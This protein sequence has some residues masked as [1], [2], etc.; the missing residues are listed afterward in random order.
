M[1]DAKLGLGLATLFV[2]GSMMGSGVY[3]LPASLGTVGSSSLLAWFAAIA[4]ALLFASVFG[5]LASDGGGADFIS[6]I[7]E[8]FGSRTA[9]VAAAFYWLQ[10]VL[11]NIALAVATTGYLSAIFP[12]ITG[13]VTTVVT[14]GILWC[15]TLLALFGPRLVARLEGWTL[16]LG[17]IPVLIAATVGWFWFD[18]AVFRASWNVSGMSLPAALPP[19]VVTILWAFLG[20]ESAGLAAGMVR[21]PAVTVPR[22]TILGVL[23]AAVVYLSACTMITGILP[24]D[25]LARSDAPF[26]DAANRLFGAGL[27]I[28]VALC[29]ALRACGTLG[30]WVL[31]TA[32]SG[33]LAVTV[34]R[35]ATGHEAG[36]SP[37]NI[38]AN[39]ALLTVIALLIADASLAR[40]FTVVIN[41][42]VIV[43]LCVYAIAAAALFR[44]RRTGD[45]RGV[46]IAT[47]LGA[48]GSLVAIAIIAT[49]P[50]EVLAATAGTLLAAMVAWPLL[51]RRR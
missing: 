29:A 7:G 25:V 38:L 39:G 35:S 3:L 33:R 46:D 51:A 49:Q 19:T 22:A 32:E 18:P 48:A 5:R 1:K 13:K 10:G 47:A 45:A 23:G 28:F 24:A 15:F 21:D 8:A 17:L 34:R 41:A 42:A 44:L 12:A 2:A 16:A 36:P 9:F 43:M 14:L 4:V 50:A 11:G 37:L 6:R 26:A 20:L 40:Q 30:G 31:L 27:G